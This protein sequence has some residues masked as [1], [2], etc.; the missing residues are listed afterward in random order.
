VRAVEFAYWLQGYFELSPEGA[1]VLSERQIQIIKN[2]LALVREV[3]KDNS[4]TSWLNGILEAIDLGLR[5]DEKATTKIQER[6]NNCFQHEID[7][8]YKGD[9]QKLAGI[10]AG[11]PGSPRPPQG[12][13]SRP[14]RGSDFGHDRL[15]RC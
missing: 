4:F 5:I 8:T 14:P 12:P 10:H 1:I 13:D 7:P 2:H 6:L 11:K 3:D 15:F 9:P